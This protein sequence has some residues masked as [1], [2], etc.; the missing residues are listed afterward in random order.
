MFGAVYSIEIG[1]GEA[2]IIMGGLTVIGGILR[3]IG[4]TL[5]AH[6]KEVSDAS[7][8]VREQFIAM[9]REQIT[10]QVTVLER[11]TEFRKQQDEIHERLINGGEK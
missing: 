4:V 10:T 5:V 2:T 8:K 11:M 6:V 3:W 1:P 9:S 7:A